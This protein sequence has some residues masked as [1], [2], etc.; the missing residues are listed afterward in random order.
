MVLTLAPI[1]AL[2]ISATSLLRIVA[3][4]WNVAGYISFIQKDYQMTHLKGW[5]KVEF[6]MV[7]HKSETH[8]HQRP[9]AIFP[10]S[11]H[12]PNYP[13][14]CFRAYSFERELCKPITFELKRPFLLSLS[15]SLSLR[16][17]SKSLQINF[18]R[19]LP[20]VGIS[21]K[22]QQQPKGRFS[23]ERER[24]NEKKSEM[25]HIIFALT[26]LFDFYELS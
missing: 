21:F 15:L 19:H 4:I 22:I 2:F 20:S 13:C 3:V 5:V 18:G 17:L 8:W 24:E 23:K 14:L 26:P 9:L 12:L 10:F 25:C 6:H 7:K 16:L 11:A 1:F